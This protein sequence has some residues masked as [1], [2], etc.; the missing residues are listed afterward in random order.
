MINRFHPSEFNNDQSLCRQIKIL[1]ELTKLHS[2]KCLK[3][4]KILEFLKFNIDNIS[5]LS[6][7]PYLPIGIFKNYE[8]RSVEK[9]KIVRTITSSGTSGQTL[10]KIYL[11]RETATEQVRV[12]AKLLEPYLGSARLPMLVLD[13]ETMVKRT[14]AFSARTAGILGFSIFGSSITYA[15][16]STMEP[17]FKEVEDFVE[18]Y[19]D[20]P[21]L[22]YGF[23][24]IAWKQFMKKAQIENRFFPLSKAVFIHGGGW[25]KIQDEAM[26]SEDFKNWAKLIFKT[27]TVV[28][29]YGLAEQIGSIFLECRSGYFHSTDY[30]N[31]LIRSFR[32]LEPVVD[33]QEGFLQ[34]FSTVPK[35]YPGHSILTE[36]VGV[37]HG[38]DDC[39]CGELGT[40][41][42]VKGRIPQAEIRGCSDTFEQIS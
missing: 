28:N 1:K 21:V 25:K 31:V 20:V 34:T 37:I 11:D 22:I 23:T 14:E 41:F 15:L 33:F 26:S 3:Y 40:Y 4:L 9:E 7:V 38:Q 42:L 2:Q 36:D 18:K 29:Y 24:Y 13:S 39:M 6:E 30:N 10:S 19:Q 12:L 35:S 5:S 32:N 27:E 16:D 8:M 17:N